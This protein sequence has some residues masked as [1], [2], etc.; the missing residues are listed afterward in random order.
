MANL[1]TYELRLIAGNRGIKNYKNMSRMNQSVFLKICHIMDSS[2]LQKCKI[3]HK[4]NLRK[5]QK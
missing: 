3:F 2:E 4:M 1:T 5:L